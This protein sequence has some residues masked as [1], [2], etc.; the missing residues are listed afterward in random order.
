MYKIIITIFIPLS[1]V[2]SQQNEKIINTC[3][4]S[5]SYQNRTIGVSTLSEMQEKIDIFYYNIDISID[6][7]SEQISGNVLLSG[8]VGLDQPDSIELDLSNSMIVDSIFVDN[9]LSVFLHNDNKIKIP[10]P[11]LTSNEGYDFNVQIFYH[12]QP[13]STGFGSFNFDTYNGIPHL[14]TLS[15][16]YGARDWWPCKD[17]PSDKADSVEI[18]ITL[19][20]DQIVV[21]NGLLI[22]EVSV[23]DNQK[24]YTWFESYPIS[25]YLVSITSYPYTVWH[26][27]YIGLNGDTL[28]L[29]FYVYPDHYEMVQDNYLLTKDMMKV[30]AEKFGEY[31]FMNEKYGHA[32]FGRGGGMEHQ[33]ISSMGGYSEWL[34]AHEL[35]HQ[36]WGDLITCSDFHHI[37]LNEGFAR[38]SEAIWVEA[39]NGPDAYKNYW[40]NH[41]YYGSGTIY[42]EDP[43]TTSQIFNGNLTYN[44][45]GWVVHMLRGVLGDS[46]FFETLQSYAYNDSLAYDAATTENFKMVCEDVSGLELDSFFEQWI[47][48]EFYPKYSLAWNTN[49]ENQLQINISQIQ[50]WQFFDMPIEIAVFTDLD[51]FRLKVDNYGLSQDYF[52]N[53]VNG[54]VQ[55][56]ELDPENWILKEVQYLTTDNQLPVNSELIM[57]PAFPNPFNPVVNV[58]YFIPEV[59]GQFQSRIFIYN[60]NGAL[61][62][63]L[64][65]V[66]SY[67]GLN[68]IS[69]DASGQA[70][71]VYFLRVKAESKSYTQKIQLIK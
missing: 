22:Q 5:L 35:G 58:N 36:W 32:E 67:P 54:V 42:V 33:T 69:W 44:K 13:T 29:D 12:G 45:A 48:G 52:I 4:K 2:F 43:S 31:P 46:L 65:P 59:V 61:V 24:K 10:S 20:E 53:S 71:G 60:L 30:F 11:E 14:W 55:R 27:E 37:W 47:Y 17:D 49:N 62:K 70:S 25:T 41:T 28:P 1:I 68:K 16:P 63:E 6:I 39:S 15:E 3:G 51:T 40:S 23:G 18:S 34:I 57:Y 38:F 56:V 19:Q 8:S 21:S 64:D 9:I 26:D 7:E 50:N 66:Q